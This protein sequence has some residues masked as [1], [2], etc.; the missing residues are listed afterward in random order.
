VADQPFKSTMPRCTSRMVR[1]YTCFIRRLIVMVR[2]GVGRRRL[3]F[4]PVAAGNADDHKPSPNRVMLMASCTE[5][6]HQAASMAASTPRPR[7]SFWIRPTASSRSQLMEA[8]PTYQ[9]A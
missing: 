3:K 5:W 9:Q 4:E 2:P 6:S 1:G 7:V 8:R